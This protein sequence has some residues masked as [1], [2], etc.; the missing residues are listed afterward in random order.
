MALAN[1]LRALSLFVSNPYTE[2][3][4]IA[5]L[6][7]AKLTRVPFMGISKISYGTQEND[8][9]IPIFIYDFTILVCLS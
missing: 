3:A 6:L 1:A 7:S 9:R 5:A 4:M 8:G 2:L